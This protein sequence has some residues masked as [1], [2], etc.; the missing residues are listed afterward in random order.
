MRNGPNWVIFG[1]IQNKQ[2]VFQIIIRGP[3]KRPA[4]SS[5]HTAF[6]VS[7]RNP[8]SDA[9][10]TEYKMDNYVDLLIEEADGR[11]YPDFCRLLVVMWWNL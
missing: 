4:V 11:C 10:Q 9:M 6:F 3:Y 7:G 8:S 1:D 2:S 5:K